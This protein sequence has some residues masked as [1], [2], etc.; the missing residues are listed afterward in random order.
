[1]D[2]AP[3]SHDWFDAAIFDMDGLLVD[4]E[5][6]WNRAIS[7]VMGSLGLPLTLAR[8]R[9]TTGF[10][11]HEIVAYW[12]ARHPWEGKSHDETVDEIRSR[13]IALIDAEAK[14]KPGSVQALELLRSAGLPLALASGSYVRI[15]DTVVDKLGFRPYFSVIHSGEHE[16]VGKPDPAIFLTAA[17]KLDVAPARCVVFE[18]SPAGVAAARAAGMRVV[19]VPDGFPKD[20]PEF[21]NADLILDS[22]ADLTFDHLT[23]VAR[24]RPPTV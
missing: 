3:W 19:A 8:V 12:A 7:E 4:S 23:L 2:D 15:I 16:R 18:D 22:L 5:P 11:L 6:L 24:Q 13:V 20:Y 10:R 17:C 9:E 14:P 1:M 21:K